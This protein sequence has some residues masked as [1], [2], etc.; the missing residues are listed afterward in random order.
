MLGEERDGPKNFVPT[1]GQSSEIRLCLSERKADLKLK[2][3]HY[4]AVHLMGHLC[5]HFIVLTG[6][7]IRPLP[8]LRQLLP[9]RPA[10]LR[11][12][13]HL[14]SAPGCQSTPDLRQP[15]PSTAILSADTVT[16]AATQCVRPTRARS[17]V[18]QRRP[19]AGLCGAAA[20]LRRRGALNEHIGRPGAFA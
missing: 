16:S 3:V 2:N 20:G 13:S 14:R 11:P 18:E 19:V 15:P 1:N 12:A 4:I 10:P 17:T 8:C 7:V 6:L 9:P 5:S